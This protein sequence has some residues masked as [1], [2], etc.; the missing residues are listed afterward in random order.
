MEPQTGTRPLNQRASAKE[1]AEKKAGG[2]QGCLGGYGGVAPG[3]TVARWLGRRA[4]IRRG[5]W[6]AATRDLPYAHSSRSAAK[7]Q[8]EKGHQT[9]DGDSSSYLVVP[10]VVRVRICSRMITVLR[11]RVPRQVRSV[12]EIKNIQTWQG[13]P[14]FLTRAFPRRQS[15]QMTNSAA[16][17][18]VVY[19]RH[20][21]TKTFTHA[22]S[23]GPNS[24]QD[25]ETIARLISP[26]YDCPSKRLTIMSL[27]PCAALARL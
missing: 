9:S 11:L 18:S 26:I 12:W 5:G 22:T 16:T 14:P 25:F 15:Y 2:G 3:W 21:L 24:T 23:G 20:S 6:E 1:E 10:S 4:E 19:L 27:P 17:S 7:N 13:A 8:M